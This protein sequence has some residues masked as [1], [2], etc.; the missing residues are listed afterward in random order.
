MKLRELK[1][2]RLVI[3]M[4]HKNRFGGT[5]FDEDED[6]RDFGHMLMDDMYEKHQKDLR[7]D[8]WIMDY[9]HQ[10]AQAAEHKQ[11]EKMN[12]EEYIKMKQKFKKQ[13]VNGNDVSGEIDNS[14]KPNEV[15]IDEGISVR[16]NSDGTQYR[17]RLSSVSPGKHSLE[18]IETKL[19]G[20]NLTPTKKDIKK[21]RTFFDEPDKPYVPRHRQEISYEDF[22]EFEKIAPMVKQ[23]PHESPELKDMNQVLAE[24]IKK[25]YRSTDRFIRVQKYVILILALLEIS[26]S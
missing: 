8:D 12:V 17:K 21:K 6:P 11:K 9:H 13:Q 1:E 25:R 5:D 19:N 3:Y 16:R 7:I 18:G 14:N 22:A 23:V 2:M 20:G 24:H 26:N 15:S 4:V 10:L